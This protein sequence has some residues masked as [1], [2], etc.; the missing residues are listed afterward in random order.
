VE[1]HRLGF[2]YVD[3]AEDE[4][5]LGDRTVASCANVAAAPSA[6]H[7]ERA[8]SRQ[9]SVSDLAANQRPERLNP[10]TEEMKALRFDDWCPSG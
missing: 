6:P 4:L 9:A 10:V 2:P 8:V 1:L 5:I 7:P 3:A